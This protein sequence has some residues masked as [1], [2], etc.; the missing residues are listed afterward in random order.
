M[1]CKTLAALLMLTFALCSVARADDLVSGLSTDLIQ[2]T[3]DFTGAEFV[4]FGAIET[5]GT[6]PR[7][8][9]RDVIVIIRGP[10]V[11]LT[12]RRKDRF[13]GIWINREQIAFRGMPSYYF[14]ASTKPLKEIASP[15]T[16]ARFQLGSANLEAASPARAAPAEISA[17]KAAAVRT[18]SRVQLYGEAQGGIEFLSKSLFR[19]R[20][21]VPAT[22]QP[23]QYRAEVYLFQNGEV[24]SAQSTPLFIDKTGLERQVYNFANQAPFS[25]GLVAVV[26]AFAFGWLG[27]VLFRQR[28]P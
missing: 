22:V 2:I 6:N 3:S 20:I 23:G 7:N 21:P 17:F 10:D 26:I 12:V 25:Y 8:E 1:K 14:M 13:L 28:I 4:V 24:A 9:N 15:G 19:A 27:F 11:D 5:T 16:L 18:L